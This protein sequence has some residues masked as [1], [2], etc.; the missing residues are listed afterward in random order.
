MANKLDMMSRDIVQEN[1]KYISE[2]FPNALTEVKEDGELVKKIDFDVL[3]QELSNAVISEKQ[4]RYQMTW[5]DKKKSI[6]LAN[7]R[8]NGTLRPVKEKS[9]DFDNT[10]NLYIEGDNLDVLKLLRETY[11][12]KVKMIYIDPPY[13]TGNDFVYEDNFSQSSDE[14]LASSGQY[15]EQG[16]RLFVNTDRN[17][18]FHTDWLNMIYPRIK[19][20]KDL[21]TEDGVIAISMDDYEIDNLK[22]I[23]DELFGEKNFLA[24][25][26]WERAYSPVNTKKHFSKSHDYILFYAKNITYAVCN[27]LKRTD[28][29][30]KRYSNPDNDPRGV[31][32]SSDFSV[33]PRVDKNVYEIIT[34]SGRSVF[35]PS[36]RCWRVTNKRYNDLLKDNRVWFGENGG[37]VPSTKRFL[38]EVKQGMTP[39]TIWKYSEVGHTQE[40]AKQLKELF[41]G[42]MIFDYSK[43]VNLI[44]RVIELY[45]GDNDL[46]LD[47]FS[48]SGTTAHAVLSINSE[49]ETTRKFIMV[50][51]PEP[52][53]EKSEPYK[54]GYKNICDIGEERIRRAGKK[55]KE[56]VAVPEES[57][58]DIGF[59]VLKLD[60][61]NMNDVFYNP[62]K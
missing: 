46:I 60:S 24:C 48:G 41:D 38:T 18:R 23:T 32:K 56:E 25:V 8:I 4:E 15:D 12:A 2:R 20:A 17:G 58:L 54:A 19:V 51:I 40:A 6:L 16:N 30:D 28:V 29:A 49:F 9:V 55:I 36:G 26:V 10:K 53:N 31:W 62:N 39:T 42:V 44:K 3:K 43:P 47:F 45:T 21:L 27:G 22:K 59:R 35:P 61:S 1:I 13:N 52:C 57:N 33:G 34:P 14:Y 5:P 7:T 11:L 50:Q 37:N